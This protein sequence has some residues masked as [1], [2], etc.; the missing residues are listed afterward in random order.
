MAASLPQNRV[1]LWYQYCKCCSRFLERNSCFMNPGSN[2]ITPPDSILMAPVPCGTSN[3][4]PCSILMALVPCGASTNLVPSRWH[5]YRVV[6]VPC[7]ILMAPVPCDISNHIG[8]YRCQ[9]QRGE[10]APG[11]RGTQNR[12]GDYALPIGIQIQT[13]LC[14][15]TITC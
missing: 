2:T 13:S 14:R 7:S 10:I 15:A 6:S 5:Q 3:S 12:Q 9:N 1:M 4:D 11:E 8:S